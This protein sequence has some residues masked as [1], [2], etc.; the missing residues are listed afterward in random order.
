MLHTSICDLFRIDVPIVLAGMGGITSPS[1]P[2]LAAAV[3]NA[4][5]LGVLGGAFL[6]A[7]ELAAWIERTRTLTDKPFGVDTLLPVRMMEGDKGGGPVTWE[8]PE[9]HA[10]FAEDFRTRH[11]LPPAQSMPPLFDQAFID[12]QMEVVLDLEVPVYVAGLGD[13]GPY[14]DRLHAKGITVGSVVGATR[15]AERALASGVDFVVAQGHDGGGHNSRIG[16][17][18]LIPQVVDA[19]AGQVPVLGAGS[20]MDGRSLVAALALGAEG[21]WCGSAF[22][23]TEEA[24]IPDAQKQAILASDEDGTVVTR[25]LTGKPARAIRSDWIEAF[26]AAGLE[27]LRMPLQGL[28]AHGVLEPALHE[29]RAD[30]FAGAAGQGIGLV[31]RIRP[32]AEVVEQMVREAHTILTRS[33]PERITTG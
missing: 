28:L 20:I 22:L 9:A 13:P 16:T 8:I 3:S 24:N 19:V 17:M 31:D 26:D 33:L 21:V 27:P 23:A 2:E 14:I 32:A 7:D 18:A 11:D 29:G 15:H 5:G 12:R 6:E 10:Q 30:L 4:G 25:T 1:G